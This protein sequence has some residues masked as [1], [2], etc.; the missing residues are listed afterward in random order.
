MKPI[1]FGKNDTTFTTN[2]LGRLD[3]L[4][5]EVVEERNGMYELT[6]VI[7]ETALHASEI[8]MSSII[9]AKPSHGASLQ[10]FRVYKI[11]KP[12]NGRFAVYAQHISYQL[13]YIPTMPFTVAASASACNSTLQALK[14]NAAETCPFTFWTNV[15]TVASYSQATPAS[16]RSRLGGVEGSVLDQFGGEYEWD[17]YY[18]KLWSHRGLTVPAVTLRYGKN[19][20]DI[21]QEEAISNTITGYCPFWAASDGSAVVTLPEKVVESQY[22]SQYPF[23]RTVPLDLSENWEEAPTRAQ[24]RTA[25]QAQV[26]RDGIG[27]PTV[28]IKV[29]FIDLS[30]TEEYKDLMTLQTVKLCDRIN[31][32]FEKLGI[33]TTAKVFKTTYNVLKEKYISIEIGSVHTSLAHTISDTT[34][35]ID[36]ALNKALFATQSATAWLTSSN[37]YVHAVKNSDGT[38]KEL[39]FADTDDPTTWHNLLRINENGI[40]FSHDGG[41]TY[42]QAWTLDGKM[43]VGGTAMPS[44]TVYDDQQN[45]LFQ[46][47]KDGLMWSS[48]YSSMSKSGDILSFEEI[49]TPSGTQ[50]NETSIS[51]GIVETTRISGTTGGQPYGNKANIRGGVLTL[52]EFE[53]GSENSCGRLSCY[54]DT[55]ITHV[56]LVNLDENGDD[57]S[58]V[59]LAETGAYMFSDENTN[60]TVSVEANGKAQV[61]GSSDVRIYSNNNVEINSDQSLELVC[62]SLSIN[63]N[64]TASGGFYD[65]DGN[66]ITVT[67]GHITGGI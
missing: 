43:V 25:A 47:D 1:L 55:G 6:L 30:E 58:R 59:S 19:I 21:E 23:K 28:S 48:D 3:C 51:H 32:Q 36:T 64:S 8:E 37:G 2:G 9:V 38:W 31:V 35:M 14:S 11:T 61:Y 52:Y 27:V 62:G 50:R 65:R 42:T 5:C 15:T 34:G 7:A 24:L 57:T 41:S 45:I 10:P 16:I 39:I 33:S 46:I 63:G 40:G 56:Q 4:S 67:D 12:I 20:T 54:R 13:S 44:L 49:T 18:V 60:A 29:S 17:G 66:Y 26:N 53:N 22:A